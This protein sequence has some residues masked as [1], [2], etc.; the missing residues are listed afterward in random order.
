MS[1]M[2]TPSSSLTVSSLT[3]PVPTASLPEPL[4]S[5]FVLQFTS[6]LDSLDVVGP[7]AVLPHLSTRA[8]DVR[9]PVSIMLTH[10]HTASPRWR[11]SIPCV[12]RKGP[13]DCTSTEWGVRCGNCRREHC[14]ACDNVAFVYHLAT[15]RN[16]HF[17]RLRERLVMDAATGKISGLEFEGLYGHELLLF[18]VA[19]QGA[20][21]RFRLNRGDA[22]V[23]AP[24]G[25]PAT[26]LVRPRVS[27]WSSFLILL[28]TLAVVLLAVFLTQ[29]LSHWHSR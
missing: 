7:M 13:G 20:I 15:V 8:A 1:L 28:D 27:Y 2:S 25:K 23:L 10:R 18:T 21:D 6:T 26:G 24:F 16:I 5:P 17:T 29:S 22:M 4:V 11:F 12:T 3:T 19:A 14:E 9:H